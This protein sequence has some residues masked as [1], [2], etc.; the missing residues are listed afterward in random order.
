MALFHELCSPSSATVLPPDTPPDVLNIFL[1]LLDVNNEAGLTKFV[2]SSHLKAGAQAIDKA[3]TMVL[4]GRML[5]NQF[6]VVV[7]LL[8][9]GD[10]IVYGYCVCHCRMLNLGTTTKAMLYNFIDFVLSQQNH[11]FFMSTVALVWPPISNL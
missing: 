9:I 5:S 8:W 11:I 10:A 6:K 2:F 4:D 3:L 1:P 7:L